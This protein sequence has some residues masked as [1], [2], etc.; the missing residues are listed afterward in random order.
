M[1]N[2][3]LHQK[4]VRLVTK[5]FLPIN[6]RTFVICISLVLLVGLAGCK[7]VSDDAESITPAAT[8][9]NVNDSSGADDNNAAE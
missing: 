3:D 1:K 7:N 8:N 6:L 2:S 4:Y 5:Q 9:E